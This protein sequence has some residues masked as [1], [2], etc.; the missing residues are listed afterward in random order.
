MSICMVGASQDCA[1]ASRKS[2][3]GKKKK[4]KGED[5]VYWKMLF[6][7][8]DYVL[9]LFMRLQHIP[10]GDRSV[11]CAKEYHGSTSLLAVTVQKNTKSTWL[12]DSSMGCCNLP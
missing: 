12:H 8:V 1:G 4:K 7:L 5:E 6:S 10:K 3:G 9:S 2:N 11:E